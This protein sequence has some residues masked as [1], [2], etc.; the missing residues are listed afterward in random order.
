MKRKDIILFLSAIC[1]LVFSWIGFTLYHINVTSTIEEPLAIQ[2]AGIKPTFDTKTIEKLKKREKVTPLL[3]NSES[4]ATPS[5][6][7]VVSKAP[8][9]TPTPTVVV[10]QTNITTPSATP[11]LILQEGNANSL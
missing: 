8:T 1:I 3:E 2:I 6:T 10:T 9:I 4:T 7:P 5:G 11:T